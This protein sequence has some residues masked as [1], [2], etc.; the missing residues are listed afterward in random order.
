M[1]VAARWE[2]L[3]AWERATGLTIPRPPGPLAGWTTLLQVVG[4][5]RALARRPVDVPVLDAL[6]LR[7]WL[8]AL[9]R[10]VHDAEQRPLLLLSPVP[11][12]PDPESVLLR[13]L[14]HPDPSVRAGA[15]RVLGAGSHG[16]AAAGLLRL[17]E[18]PTPDERVEAAL[19]LG[20][21]GGPDVVARFPQVDDE[22]SV[23]GARLE[24]VGTLAA[25][26]GWA[27][28]EPLLEGSGRVR[29]LCRAVRAGR[30]DGLRHDEEALRH[31]VG[32]CLAASAEVVAEQAAAVAEVLVVHP[33]VDSQ[34]GVIRALGAGGEEGVELAAEMLGHEDWAVRTAGAMVL[35]EVGGAAGQVDG[36]LRRALADADADVQREAAL[37]RQ[38]AGRDPEAMAARMARRVVRTHGF[39]ER[40]RRLGGCLGAFDAVVHDRVPD[41]ELLARLTSPHDGD[42]ACVAAL[43]LGVCLGERARSTFAHMAVDRHHRVPLPLRRAAAAA[44]MGGVPA[45]GGVVHRLLLAHDPGATGLG[46]DGAHLGGHGGELAALALG[47]PDAQVRWSA[48]RALRGLGEG[49]APHR[50]VLERVAMADPVDVVRDEARFAVPATWRAEGAGDRLA[51]VLHPDGAGGGGPQLLALALSEPERAFALARGLLDHDLRPLGVAAAR[52]VGQVAARDGQGVPWCGDALRRL[53]EPSWQAREVAATLLEA[54]AGAELPAG[55]ADEALEALEVTAENDPDD[56]V[57]G[58]ASRALVAWRQR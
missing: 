51:D 9:G 14:G 39:V 17:V 12:E 33:G 57:R 13:L 52:V 5:F 49:V 26:H 53:V 40:V 41:E 19:G 28:L 34:R 11:A 4:P 18:A 36:A 58:A 54:L 30:V 23:D 46:L 48:V 1:D 43:W 31:G 6:T 47:D 20:R 29:A 8:Q 25:R 56:D 45:V 10:P 44:A 50:A 55:L 32:L 24:A 3:L 42:V 16:G 27:A 2:G 7:A 35:Q 38:L 37:A 22:A 21:L 15:A